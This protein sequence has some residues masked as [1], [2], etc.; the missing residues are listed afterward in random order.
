MANGETSDGEESQDTPQSPAQARGAA[1]S[2][3]E[4][5]E[6]NVSTCI[7]LVLTGMFSN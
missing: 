5:E 1:R 6:E 4:N 3:S 7:F 2:Q